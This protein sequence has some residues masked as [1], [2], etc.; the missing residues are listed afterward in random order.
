MLAPLQ[1]Q[2]LVGHYQKLAHMLRRARPEKEAEM[3]QLHGQFQAAMAAS[4]RP[5]CDAL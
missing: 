1:L 2:S 5:C 4:V 3:A